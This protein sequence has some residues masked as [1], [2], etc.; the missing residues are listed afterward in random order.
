MR[1]LLSG[2]GTAGH[3]NPAIA[4]AE[5]VKRQDPHAAIA[6]VGTPSGMEN[7]LVA[8]TGYPMY[9]V[10]V[11]GFRRSLSPRNIAALWLAAVSP[12]RADRILTEF[13]PDAVIGTGGYVSWPILRAAAK[14]GIPTAVHESNAIPGMAVRRL[15]PVLNEIWLNFS[16][17]EKNLPKNNSVISSVGNPIREGF[18]MVSRKDA[19]QK[20]GLSERELFLL[21][22]G[23]SLGAEAINR[24]VLSTAREL[25]PC[26]SS[27]RMIHAAGRGHYQEIKAE[28]DG[29]GSPR[30]TVLPYI[31]NMPLYM[32]AADIVISRAGAMTLSEL[33][34]AEKCA[35]LIPSPHVTGDH[36]YKNAAVFANARAASLIEERELASGVLCGEVARLLR[37]P[38]LRHAREKEIRRFARADANER[39]LERL[40]LMIQKN[41][42]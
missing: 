38:A 9:H 31:E 6:F 5:T 17:A 34:L 30:L 18:R 26:H 22:F 32:G 29:I 28:A 3:V 12:L 37:D 35:I 36:Q 1:I 10:N 11:R 25:L 13:R 7:R 14:R 20:L 41:K 2:G 24:A 40:L 15:A 19:R 8:E 16:E 23:G 21:S 42:K 39:I 27:L 4:I 33:A